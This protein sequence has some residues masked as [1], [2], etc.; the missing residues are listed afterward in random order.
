[1]DI[2]IEFYVVNKNTLSDN[3]INHGFPL[4]SI[5]DFGDGYYQFIFSQLINESEFTDYLTTIDNLSELKVIAKRDI[6]KIA[7]DVRL[8]YVSGGLSIV[9]EYRIAFTEASNY[10]NAGFT[11]AIPQSVQSDMDYSGRNNVYSTYFILGMANYYDVVLNNVR[12]LRLGKKKLIT[13][14]NNTNTIQTILQESIIE[15]N[16]MKNVD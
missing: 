7:D 9:E 8:S 13:L 10:L 2:T 15:F 14:A 16:S 3:I 1:M 5:T 4:I 12:T 6:D 11:G